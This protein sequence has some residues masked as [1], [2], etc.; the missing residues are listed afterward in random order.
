MSDKNNKES[1]ENT[2]E[3]TEN[4]SENSAKDSNEPS[5]ENKNYVSGVDA[6]GFNH[7]KM[8]NQ[9]IETEIKKSYLDYAMSVIVGRALPDVRDGLK[10]VH[11]RIL[12]AM[13]DLG[14]KFG[15]SY[16]KSARL[17]GEV[18]GKYHPHGDSSV[19]EAMVRM[20]QPFSLRY[21]LV[22]GQ[23]NFGSVDG[24]SAAAMR[25]TE[26]RMA[27]ITDEMLADIDKETVDFVDNFDGSL[28]EP[29]VLPA[30]IPNLL[31][32][33]STGIAV[34]MATNIP[35]HN[36]REVCNAVIAMID[37]PE[38]SLPELLSIVTG[39]DFPTGGIIAGRSGIQQ[40]YLTGKG[41]LR[42]KSVMSVEENKRNK[43][44]EK[45]IITE[46]PYTVNKA[47]LVEQI[48]DCVKDKKIEGISDLRDES[49]RKGMRIVIELKRDASPEIVQ[50]Q[51]L[52]HTRLQT[53]FGI[54]MLALENGI[55]KVLNLK[56]VLENYL[57]H[58]KEIITRRTEYNLKKAEARA[59]ILDGL[60][61][62]LADIDS[63]VKLIK[64]SDN[65]VEA[66][67]GLMNDYSL[68]EIQSNA[69]LDMKLQKLTGLETN[70]IKNELADLKEKISHYKELLADINKV[71]SIIKEELQGV[72]EKYGDDRKTRIDEFD[73]ENIDIDD[74]IEPE[75]VVITISNEGY[76]KRISLDA[77]KSQRRGGVG[78]KGASTKE[79]DFIEKLFIANTKDY[80]L[81]FT[82]KGKIY[83]KKTYKLP[84][85]SRQSKGKPFINLINI[86][87][88]E[89][90]NA[91]IPIKE[92]TDN[93]YLL[94]VT[95]KG[96]VKKTAL[97]AYS[98]VRQGG[99]RAINLSEDN[100]LVTVIK[101]NGSE[102]ILL[103]SANGQAVKFNE[104]DAR[105][106]GRVSTGVRGIRLKGNDFVIGA[107]KASDEHSILTVTENGFGKRTKISDYRLIN[108]GGSGVRNI[109][110][111]SRNGKVVAIRSISDGEDIML[112][113]K[114]GIVIRTRS[115]DINIIG[116]NT[117]GV[118][119]MNLREGDKVVAVAK[120]VN[121]DSDEVQE[122]EE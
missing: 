97:S 10:P 79:D 5:N 33:G 100:D 54:T 96:I 42:L 64:S 89:K 1:E 9:L 91:V 101:T 57:L 95:K 19:Y 55:P 26:A 21:M 106:L 49:D 98:N 112:S 76:V 107:I 14:M 11:R 30:K 36:L 116:R 32:N 48:A 71:L 67:E 18:L 77:Y 7:G 93:E 51:L 110:C 70:K 114:N 3:N 52:K 56:E 4:S 39:P 35:P 34:G 120:I 85:G 23:G 65:V 6:Q 80:L 28:K 108:R 68:T 38:I 111:S 121:E 66:R 47:V 13:N 53:S 81:V 92:F 20:A 88:G 69:I 103:A 25:Y 8:F 2:Q 29:S 117:Q 43:D 59:H 115:S 87:K 109:I 84:D 74:L 58:R 102:Q 61:I 118:K 50:N 41:I 45:I 46:I 119:L 17:V 22:D 86:E 105:P 82:D 94:F 27:K 78:V 75:E 113:S 40:A 12:Y 60:L 104:K 122:Q 63:V 62:A 24:D 90:I 83:W 31:I 73:D 16:K 99:I 72:I 44:K 15:S 37:N